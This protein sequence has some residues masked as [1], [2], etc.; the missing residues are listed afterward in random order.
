MIIDILAL[1]IL[2]LCI[3]AGMRRG[4]AR[5]FL[6]VLSFVVSIVAGLLLY[7]SFHAWFAASVVGRFLTD[8]ISGALA[9]VFGESLGG[10]VNQL[11]LPE[12]LQKG[13]E[14][15]G[16]LTADVAASAA[17]QLAALVVGVLAVVLLILLIRLALKL[18]MHVVSGMMKLPVLRQFNGLLGGVFGAL[19]GLFWVWI[20]LSVVGFLAVLPAFSFLAGWMSGSVAMDISQDGAL[21]LGAFVHRFF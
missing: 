7:S 13:L 3:V 8:K 21:L 18:I 15:A 20:I 17:Q 14:G 19:S 4:F 12:F 16:E 6:G 10:A 9:G 2:V 1:T 11:D 5:A